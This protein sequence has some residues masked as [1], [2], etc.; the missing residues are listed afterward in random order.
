MW[1]V[2]FFCCFC[3][4]MWDL[5][6]TTCGIFP[7]WCSGREF[8]CNAGD[9]GG[10]QSMGSQRVGH[11]QATKNSTVEHLSLFLKRFI[12]LPMLCLTC[13]MESLIIYCGIQTLH[14]RIF[15]CSIWDRVPGPG[16]EAGPPAWGAWILS[17]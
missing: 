5:L 8:A 3:C 1:H 2:G 12:Y 13:G 10:L 11:E 7:R 4:S 16:I 9:W 14:C 15:S 6:V 17:H